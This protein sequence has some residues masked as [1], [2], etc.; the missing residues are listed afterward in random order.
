MLT[1]F[2][3]SYHM[4]K[5]II[6]LLQLYVCHI[7][8]HAR[9]NIIIPRSITARAYKHFRQSVAFAQARPLYSSICLF[10]RRL[11]EETFT[12]LFKLLQW[13]L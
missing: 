8:M 9:N 10:I 3:D 4:Q 6:V 2:F 12:E 7:Y 1:N 5:Q 11:L 13:N